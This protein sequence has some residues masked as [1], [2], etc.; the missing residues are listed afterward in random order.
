MPHGYREGTLRN[1]YTIYKANGDEI[2]HDAEY[3]VLRID[4]DPHARVALREY[5]ESIIDENPKFRRALIQWLNK[6]R[7]TE[8]GQL[9]AP[10]RVD[11]LA[12]K[13]FGDSEPQHQETERDGTQ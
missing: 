9:E 7:D 5:A 2:D 8:G 4:K 3:F 1:K 11:R 10:M 13:I 12:K 6:T